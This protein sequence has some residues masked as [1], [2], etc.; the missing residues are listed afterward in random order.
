MTRPP[1][2]WHRFEDGDPLGWS[3]AW[4]IWK[5]WLLPYRTATLTIRYDGITYE[6]TLGPRKW[7]RP[8]ALRRSKEKT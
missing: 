2:P 5:M 7:N 6:T 4:G 3:D 1:M 8:D